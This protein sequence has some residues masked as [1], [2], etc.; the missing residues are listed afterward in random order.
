MVKIM[1]NP[2]KMDDLGGTPIFGNTHYIYIHLPYMHG[3]YGFYRYIGIRVYHPRGN[4]AIC[5]N[6]GTVFQGKA[7]QV[8]INGWLSGE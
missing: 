1:E 3:W 4:P 7:K 5:L 8:L 2:I 6:S